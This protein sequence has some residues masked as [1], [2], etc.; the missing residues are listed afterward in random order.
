LGYYG[1]PC[2]Q[3]L[4]VA[5]FLGIIDLFLAGKV[6]YSEVKE[7]YFSCGGSHPRLINEQKVHIRQPGRVHA[8]HHGPHCTPEAHN[9]GLNCVNN[10]RV[11]GG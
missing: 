1:P 5:G 7:T 2:A 9:P 11:L 3:G 4:S 8:G 10:P 6:V